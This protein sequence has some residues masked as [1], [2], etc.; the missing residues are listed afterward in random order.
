VYGDEAARP[1]AVQDLS[2]RAAKYGEKLA[3]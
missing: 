3:T 2:R 1:E